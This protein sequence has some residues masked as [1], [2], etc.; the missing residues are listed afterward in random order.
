MLQK[1]LDNAFINNATIHD[2][3]KVKL[4][5]IFFIA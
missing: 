3:N 1:Y 5:I 2:G 4:L